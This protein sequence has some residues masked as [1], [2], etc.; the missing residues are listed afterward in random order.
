VSDRKDA[1]D[2]AIAALME[3]AERREKQRHR[4][5]QEQKKAKRDAERTRA[6]YDLPTEL[7]TV[8]GRIASMENMSKSAT[9]ALLLAVAAR[10]FLDGS[11]DFTGAKTVIQHPLY[12]W[13][14]KT[15]TILEILKGDRNL[16]DR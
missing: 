16:L 11:L 10:E 15:D 12:N 9:A 3:Q 13:V 14:V 7:Q 1:L 4:S 6:T 5:P 2:P 8:V